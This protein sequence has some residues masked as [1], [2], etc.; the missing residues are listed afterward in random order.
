MLNPGTLGDGTPAP[1]P[2]FS[3]LQ[4]WL[5]KIKNPALAC[6][7]AQ[8]V[9]AGMTRDQDRLEALRMAIRHAITARSPQA[10]EACLEGESLAVTLLRLSRATDNNND[11]DGDG[12]DD[13]AGDGDQDGGGGGDVEEGVDVVDGLERRA[14]QLEHHMTAKECVGEDMA[15]RLLPF[16]SSSSKELLTKIL[17]LAAESAA[18]EALAP[19][20]PTSSTPSSPSTNSNPTPFI[21]PTATA[22]PTSA[23]KARTTADMGAAGAV[24][25]RGGGA[26]RLT[27]CFGGNMAAFRQRASRALRAARSVAD[28]RGLDPHDV[29]TIILRL[30]KG[31]ICQPKSGGGG[32][33]GG[34]AGEGRGGGVFVG[35][36]VRGSEGR[37]SVFLKDAREERKV[38]AATLAIQA[39]FVLPVN[40]SHEEEEEDATVCDSIVFM[41]LKSRVSVLLAIAKD[42]RKD[43]RAGR[44]KFRSRLRALL[45]LSALAPSTLVAEVLAGTKD[46]DKDGWKGQGE[47]LSSLSDLRR[48]VGYMSELEEARLPHKLEELA[49]CPAEDIVRALRRDHRR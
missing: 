43:G 28:Q 2:V 1:V 38:Q 16:F 5:E 17:L 37:E 44:V 30:A 22:T 21:T 6:M 24:S 10:Q 7:T 48:N 39:A 13:D 49:S 46:G 32:G 26:E 33:G 25:L 29:E 27:K 41:D 36:G 4:P 12:G 11:D 3:A 15:E 23:A 19:P 47:G 14:L 45:A 8:R 34:G 42:C 9:A 40:F 31:W 35:G 18:E 20:P